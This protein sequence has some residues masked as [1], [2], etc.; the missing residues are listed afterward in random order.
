[1]RMRMRFSEARAAT[2]MKMMMHDAIR[3]LDNAHHGGQLISSQSRPL[4]LN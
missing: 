1:M 4:R 2:D 3:A